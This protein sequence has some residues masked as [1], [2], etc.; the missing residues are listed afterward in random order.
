MQN[1]KTPSFIGE[2]LETLGWAMT[3]HLFIY[4][5]YRAACEILDPWQGIEPGPSA[6]IEP[7]SPNH[8]TAREFP[9]DDFLDTTPKA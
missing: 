3:F 2:N 8:R 7:Q 4:W 1:Y 5:P 6:G 9:G